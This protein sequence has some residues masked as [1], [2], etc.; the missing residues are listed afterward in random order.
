MIRKVFVVFVY[1]TKHMKPFAFCKSGLTSRAEANCYHLWKSFICWK[2][3]TLS[4]TKSMSHC[5]LIVRVVA[6]VLGL[7]AGSNLFYFVLL[8]LHFWKMSHYFKLKSHVKLHD[9]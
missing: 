4:L 1:G 7:Y 6:N 9:I 3:F 8:F 5:D 2:S